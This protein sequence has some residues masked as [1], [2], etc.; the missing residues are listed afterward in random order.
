MTKIS[1]IMPVYNVEK[2]I[3]ECLNSIL[4]QTLEDI[5]V[6]CVDDGSTDN[7]LEIL[8]AYAAKDSRIIVINKKNEGSGIARNA[9]IK[10]AGGEYIHFVDSDDW[11]Y[12]NKVYEE[13]YAKAKEDNLDILIFGGYSCYVSDKG[14]VYKSKGGYSLKTLPRKYLKGI[15]S[16]KDI[17]KD[18]F[19]FP[20]T[21]WTKLYKREF[22]EKN[23]ILFQE[24]RVGQDQL[25]F[26]HSMITAE[27]IE[28]LNKCFYCYRKNRP[29]SAMTVKKKKHFSPVYVLRGIEEL[30]LQLGKINE[31]DT[32][33][34]D[35]YFSKATSW[36]AKFEIS[37]KPSYYREYIKTL[38]HI[39]KTY[40]KGWWKYFKPNVEDS[41]QKLKGKIFLAKIKYMLL[42]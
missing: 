16:A 14:K 12:N 1:V 30:L 7:S 41:Y 40:P 33:F 23:Q 15:F 13:I 18:I 20:S 29:N 17:K 22:L 8:N 42:K 34:I 25:P 5:E 3:G 4:T 6:I 32:I 11:L 21:A 2:Y 38:N 27:R 24:I 26:F 37:L 36:L 19:T 28:V 10:A 31:Y 39:R 9:G 35:K